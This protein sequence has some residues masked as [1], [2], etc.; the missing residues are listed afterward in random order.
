[1]GGGQRKLAKRFL[2][3]NWQKHEGNNVM[4]PPHSHKTTRISVIY[5]YSY[6]LLLKLSVLTFHIGEY[7]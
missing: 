7:P 5:S 3:F 4:G 2:Q 6:R 1:M